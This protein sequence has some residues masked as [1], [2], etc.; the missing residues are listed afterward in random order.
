MKM[1]STVATNRN[2]IFNEPKLTLEEGLSLYEGSLFMRF[3][4]RSARTERASSVTERTRP[5]H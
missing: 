1:N 3:L 5:P 4:S 2:E